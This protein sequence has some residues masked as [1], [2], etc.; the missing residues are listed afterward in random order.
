MIPSIYLEIVLVGLKVVQ[1]IEMLVQ[2]KLKLNVPLKD[3]K[4]IKQ[5]TFLNKSLFWD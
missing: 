5:C 1:S 3:K 4:K 2:E